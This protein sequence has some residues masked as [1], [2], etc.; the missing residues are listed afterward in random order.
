MGRV[1]LGLTLRRMYLLNYNFAF[2]DLLG[3]KKG[4]LIFVLV[5]KIAYL[6]LFLHL[7]L[8][9]DIYTINADMKKEKSNVH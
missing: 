4:A 8:H 1:G 6:Y 3:P 5:Q 9:E 7:S 2:A